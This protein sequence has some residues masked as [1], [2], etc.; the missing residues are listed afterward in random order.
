MGSVL[1]SFYG[2]KTKK[3]ADF[4]SLLIITYYHNI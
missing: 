2:L 1:K 4:S 3:F